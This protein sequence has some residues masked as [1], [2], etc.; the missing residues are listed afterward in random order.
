[1]AEA[2]AFILGSRIGGVAAPPSCWPASARPTQTLPSWASHPGTMRSLSAFRTLRARSWTPAAA[3]L[4][5]FSLLNLH[6]EYCEK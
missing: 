5:H 1:M 4:R 2:K 6:V 3:G